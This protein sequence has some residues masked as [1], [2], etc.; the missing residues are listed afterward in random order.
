[1]EAGNIDGEITDSRPEPPFREVSIH[2][3]K[4][5]ALPLMAASLLCRG[6][7]VLHNCPHLSDVDVSARILRHL[8]C[9]V[10]WQG[11]S[12]V[13]DPSAVSQ[14]DIPDGLMR[15]MRSSI[16]FLGAILARTGRAVLSFPAAASWGRAPLIC[17]CGRCAAWVRK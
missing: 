3:A 16:V 15:E 2:G 11:G 5:S 17:I 10:H 12:L 4:N 1:M 7:C 9:T 14:C 6:E 13:I 8:G